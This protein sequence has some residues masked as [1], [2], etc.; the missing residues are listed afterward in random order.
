MK[1]MLACFSLIVVASCVDQIPD[2]PVPEKKISHKQMVSLLTELIQLESSAQL[3]HVQINRYSK[4][5]EKEGD[6]LLQSKGF[7]AEQFE[8]NMHY[9]GSRQE[10]MMEIYDEVKANLLKEKEMLEAK[11]KKEREANLEVN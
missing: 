8:E 1:L 3:K 7:T 5:L 4:A 11:L 2:M 10:E 9:Y 6:S